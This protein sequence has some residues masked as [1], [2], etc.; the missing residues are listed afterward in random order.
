MFNYLSFALI[1]SILGPLYCRDDYDLIFVYEPSPVTVGLPAIIFKKIKK[2]PLM[3]WVQDLWPESLIATN[4]VQSKRLLMLVENIVRMIYSKCDK[5]LVQSKAFYTSIEKLGIGSE[6]ILYYPNSAESFYRPVSIQEVPE[7][8]Q[9]PKGFWVM[10]A[11]NIGAAQDFG[12]ILAAAELLRNYRDIHWIIIGDGRMRKW[13]NTEVKSRGLSETFH[14]LGSYPAES[15]PFFFAMAAVLL[16]SLKKMPIFALTIP[17]KVQ[18]YLA[19]AKPIICSL[20][21]EGAR[22]VEEANAGFACKPEDPDA[23]ATAILKAY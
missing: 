4:A 19:C 6:K 2:V 16:V 12:T 14:L 8:A 13:V 7:C 9:I 15:M 22:I 10:F 1:A 20:D 3:F 5:I 21:G 18:S 17:A 11:G 23:L